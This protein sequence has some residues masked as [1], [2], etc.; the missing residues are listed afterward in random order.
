MEEESFE[1]IQGEL[2]SLRTTLENLMN[3]LMLI[4]NKVYRAESKIKLLSRDASGEEDSPPQKKAK[5]CSPIW[6][7]QG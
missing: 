6:L 4:T 1:T 7:H 2:V 3:A 5:P